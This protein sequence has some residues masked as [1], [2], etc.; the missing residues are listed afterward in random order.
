MVSSIKSMSPLLTSANNSLI[1][2]SLSIPNARNKVVAGTRRLRSIFTPIKPV[3][4][5]SNSSHE[6]RLGMI[7]VPKNNLPPIFCAEKNTPAERISCEIQ[8]RSTP[9]TIKV[10]R[11][12]ISGKSH[13]KI[14]CVFDSLVFKL[15]S[16]TLTRIGDS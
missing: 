1:A 10:P 14:S 5:V 9:L 11:S 7:L 3:W 15:T 12:V 2:S 13:R 6:P 8:T 4:A 16:L